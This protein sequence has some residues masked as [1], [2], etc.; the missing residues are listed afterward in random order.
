MVTA[1]A[2]PVADT[3][4]M[5]KTY[6]ILIVD[7]DPAH[8]KLLTYELTRN[9]YQ[10]F[11]ANDGLEALNWIRSPQHQPDLVLLDLLMPRFSGLDVLER[12][13]TSSSKP[14]VILMSAAEY[15][16]M[17]QGVNQS[18]PDAFLTKP[19]EMKELLVQIEALLQPEVE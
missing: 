10:V 1:L 14:P 2:T 11:V 16:I 4:K 17:L 8:R 3:Q 19:L 18:E 7:D 6:R 13:K 5:K 12:I 15:P 9:G